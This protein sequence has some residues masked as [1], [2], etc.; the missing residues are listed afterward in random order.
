MNHVDIAIPVKAKLLWVRSV[1]LCD[2]KAAGNYD[3]LP[4]LEGW[5]H[6]LKWHSQWRFF[7]HYEW[8]TPCSIKIQCLLSRYS[9]AKL[10]SQLLEI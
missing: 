4:D 9:L 1:Q 7:N 6:F 3:S 2:M 10:S 8:G 5:E